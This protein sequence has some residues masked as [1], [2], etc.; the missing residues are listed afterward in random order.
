M[1]HRVPLF[2]VVVNLLAACSMLS[3]GERTKVEVVSSIDGAKQPC[4]VVLPSNYDADGKPAPLLVSLHSWSADLEQRK[5]SLE[6]EAESRGWI[7]IYPNFRGR[8][9][10]PQACGS[11]LAQQD[12]L[13][14]VAWAQKQHHVDAKR[15]YL[16]GVSGGGHMTMLM[17]A[18]H[19]NVWAAASAWVGISDLASWHE[20]HADDRYGEMLRKCC[21]GRPGDSPQVDEQYKARSPLTHLHRAVDVPL[22]IAAG[23]H[24]GHQGSVP[25]R[26]SLD[27]FNVI[28]KAAGDEQISEEEIA[29]ISRPN[30]RLESP[31]ASDQE[32]DAGFGRALYLRRTAGK[33]RV[34]IFEGGHEGI[35]RAAAEWLDGKAKK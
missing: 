9:D 3:A 26:H 30:G 7:M 20:R 24:D 11:L 21:Q 4:Y 6:A 14:A 19:P 25:V 23:V 8:N 28:A 22:D 32:E 33:S 35:T 2:A 18:R 5:P 15:I 1:N 27:A 31:R 10:H 34:T 12:I 16:T 17:A 13:D 29:Q